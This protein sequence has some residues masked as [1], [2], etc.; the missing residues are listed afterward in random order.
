MTNQEIADELRRL[1]QLDVDAVLAYDRAIAAI[2]E[3]MVASSLAAFRLDHQRHVLELSKGMLDLGVN[4]PE[5]KPDLKGSI[6]GGLTAVR[7]RLGT[8]QTLQA[9]R[10]NEQ[11][12]NGSYATA[13]A[14][15][16]PEDV[17]AIVRKGYA[18]EQRHL[19]W[20]ERTLDAR[21]WEGTGAAL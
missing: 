18:D 10:S 11:L 7:S 5:A 15:P 13:V 9:M 4:P 2:G 16:F 14:K 6:L 3:G 1:I 20:I 17:L 8:E 19:A 12:T 21:S